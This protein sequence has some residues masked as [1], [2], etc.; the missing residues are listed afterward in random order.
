MCGG[1]EPR[2]AEGQREELDSHEPSSFGHRLGSLGLST[3]VFDLACSQPAKCSCPH[4]ARNPRRG[5]SL[6]GVNEVKG[7]SV[8][9]PSKPVRQGQPVENSSIW[10]QH[11]QRTLA[12]GEV[13]GRGSRPQPAGRV[14]FGVVHALRLQ[15][16]LSRR[17]GSH[18]APDSGS[19]GYRR[20]RSRQRPV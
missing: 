15:V 12:G 9:A 5:A 14:G 13:H 4:R 7:L 18:R 17:P 2:T 8:G 3:Y 6:E 10:L 16:R 20:R 11:P 1:S 19:P